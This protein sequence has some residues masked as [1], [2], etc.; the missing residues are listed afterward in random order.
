MKN[1]KSNINLKNFFKKL[2]DIQQINTSKKTTLIY[3]IS[4]LFKS[5]ICANMA[6]TDNGIPIGGVVGTINSIIY[7][8]QKYNSKEIICVFDGKNNAKRRQKIYPEYKIDRGKKNDNVKSPLIEN[9]YRAKE[10]KELQERLLVAFLKRMPVKILNIKGLEADDVISFLINQYYEDK[11]GSRIIVTEDRDMLQL[12]N[13]QTYIHLHRKK[14]LIGVKDLNEFGFGKIPENIIYFRAVEGDKSDNLDGVNGIAKKSFLKLLPEI[15]ESKLNT[16][17][18]F[19]NLVDSK[20]DVLL[21]TKKGKKLLESKSIIDRNYK[22]MNLS[23]SNEIITSTEEVAIFEL[24]N[25]NDFKDSNI[26]GIRN[27]IKEFRLNNEL[28]EGKFKKF[29][30]K[31]RYR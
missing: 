4:S 13:D 9:L 24:M 25:K 26:I 16:I 17:D 11:K 27:I 19:F 18:D 15:S 6:V 23:N 31:I 12:L 5:H 29:F 20:R 21:K 14:E 8:S 30:N 28:S 3:D 1:K 7:L 2:D 22:L 10:N